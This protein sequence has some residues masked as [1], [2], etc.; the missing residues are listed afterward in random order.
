[1]EKEGKAVLSATLWWICERKKEEWQGPHGREKDCILEIAWH[2]PG[3]L[4]ELSEKCSSQGIFYFM[5]QLLFGKLPEAHTCSVT[6][7]AMAAE[8]KWVRKVCNTHNTCQWKKI[9]EQQYFCNWQP[10]RTKQPTVF[11]IKINYH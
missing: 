6:Y 1:M 7:T 2:R 9:Q 4:G 10:C 11:K 5:D 8:V 3:W